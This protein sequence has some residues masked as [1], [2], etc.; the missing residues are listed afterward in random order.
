MFTIKC[1]PFF[2]THREM[3]WKGNPYG[4]LYNKKSQSPYY[5]KPGLQYHEIVYCFVNLLEEI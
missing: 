4:I 5:W 2:A 1:R 3:T